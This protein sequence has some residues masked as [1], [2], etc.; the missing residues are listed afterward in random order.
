[1]TCLPDSALQRTREPNSQQRV[2]GDGP[3]RPWRLG[4]TNL[5][6]RR[7]QQTLAW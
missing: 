1:L 2:A 4:S 5:R 3:A 6:T 7:L